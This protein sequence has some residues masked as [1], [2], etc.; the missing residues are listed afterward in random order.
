MRSILWKLHN[1]FGI[2]YSVLARNLNISV[3]YVSHIVSDQRKFP[4]DKIEP[5][6]E[7]LIS[8]SK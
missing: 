1:D 7:Y 4:R 3:S 5:F 2:S 8:L 6:K